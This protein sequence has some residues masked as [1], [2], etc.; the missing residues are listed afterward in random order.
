MTM[1]VKKQKRGTTPM[2]P[3]SEQAGHHVGSEHDFEVMDHML[4]APVSPVTG[5]QYL[6]RD[7][8]PTFEDED[9]SSL[10]RTLENVFGCRRMGF[11]LERA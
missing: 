5:E 9:D 10:T 6:S 8:C 7:V 11:R 2:L 1:T 3:K 4:H